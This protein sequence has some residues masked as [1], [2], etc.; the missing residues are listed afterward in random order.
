M[1][2]TQITAHSKADDWGRKPFTETVEN[3][4]GTLK[5]AIKYCLDML[6]IISEHLEVR[7]IVIREERSFQSRE[8]EI[9]RD[10]QM[11]LEHVSAREIAKEMKK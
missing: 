2:T 9:T 8:I 5:D 4:F 11:H 3:T 1:V 7:K 6:S 10:F